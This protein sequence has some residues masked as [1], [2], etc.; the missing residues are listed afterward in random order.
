M[1][2]QY[3]HNIMIMLHSQKLLIHKITNGQKS[4]HHVVV[5]IVC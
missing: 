3:E 2:F 4:K 5:H 1:L